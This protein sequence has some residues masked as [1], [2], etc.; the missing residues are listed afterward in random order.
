MT[1]KLS[2]TEIPKKLIYKV[3][4][5]DEN[6]T[7]NKIIIFQ[8]NK[9][10][11]FIFNDQQILE[12]KENNIEIIQSEQHIHNDDSIRLIK[13]KII[14]ELGMNNIAYE[15]LYLF[16]NS[17]K[18][19]NFQQAFK[20]ITNNNKILFTK[21]MLGQLLMNIKAPLELAEKLNTNNDFYTYQ[22][23]LTIL[24]DFK[25]EY[26]IST[27]LGHQFISS[28]N[29]LYSANPYH[30]LNKE[31]PLFQLNNQNAIMNFE[32]HI[33]LD[34]PNIINNTLYVCTAN[35]VL[36]YSIRNN[37]NQEYMIELYFP[38]LKSQ[39]IYNQ[40]LLNNNREQIIEKNKQKFDENINKIYQNIDLLHNMY[41]YNNEIPFIHKGIQNI[42]MIIH[43]DTE[44]LLPLELIF[45]H[46]HAN[47]NM[48]F[49]KYN[50]G[51][52]REHMYRL[53]STEL[54]KEG[55]KIPKL[56]RNQIVTLSK[57][58]GK[59]K[60]ISIL[61]NIENETNIKYFFID[62]E[63][64]GNIIVRIE[65]KDSINEVELNQLLIT[66]VNQVI[67]TINNIIEN[68][69]YKMKLFDSIDNQNNEIINLEYVWKISI[70]RVIKINDYVNIFKG[71][72]NIVDNKLIIFKRVS[73]Y[74]E[75]DEINTIIAQNYN[76]AND[77]SFIKN[78]LL[79]NFTISEDE[80][81][82]KIKQFLNDHT[83]IHGRYVNKS[84]AINVNPGIP[85]IIT[86]N[87]IVNEL[88]INAKEI[89]SINYIN[90]LDV[91]INNLL[92]ISQYPDKL[93]IPKTTLMKQ[94]KNVEKIDD[95][96]EIK[97]QLIPV[98][99][100]PFA[101]DKTS[102]KVDTPDEDDGFFFESDDESGDDSSEE[103][104]DD[105]LN[106]GG[107]TGFLQKMKELEPNLFLT[108][109]TGQ[110]D[111]YSRSCPA[112]ISRQPIILTQEE[113][114]NIDKEYPGSYKVALP[115]ST[116]ENKKYWYIC[117][118]YWCIKPGENRPLSEE[119]VKDGKCDGKIIPK[120][121]KKPP[122][123]H[124]IYEFNDDKEHKNKDGSYRD[125]YPGLLD[126]KSHPEHCVPC[127]FK[128]F[129]SDQQINRRKECAID[130]DNLSGNIKEIYELEQKDKKGVVKDVKSKIKTSQK[131]VLDFNKYP[132]ENNRWGFL[133]LS[134]EMLLQTKNH[135]YVTKNNQ[136]LI[137]KD[138]QPLLRYGIEHTPGR[139][140]FI[141]CIADLYKK[142]KDISIH[143]MRKIISKNLTIDKFAIAQNGSLITIFKNH[144][145]AIEKKDITKH[146][147]SILF[148]TLD[149]SNKDKLQYMYDVISSYNN[150][151][152][153]LN[154][155]DAFIDHTYL[156][157]IITSKDIGIFSN[158]INLIIL[159][160]I[161]NDST[162]NIQ[163]L[164]P[165]N[166]YQKSFYNQDLK[167][168][169]LVKQDDFFEPIY[170]YGNTPN[171]NVN[172][173]HNVIKFFN[174]SNMPTNLKPILNKIEN[175]VNKY[176]KPLS[177]RPNVYSFEEALPS[178]NIYDLLIL[179]N[180]H[181]V[182]QVLNYNGKNIGFLVSINKD[183]LISVYVPCY[184]SNII[185]NIEITYPDD[186]KW[187]NYQD[188]LSRLQNINSISNN[189]IKCKPI[190]KIIEDNLI[191]GVLT[192]TNQFI[193][194]DTYEQNTEQDNLLSIQ[195]SSYKHYYNIDK[196]FLLSNEIDTIRKNTVQKISLE[197]QLYLAFRSKIRMLLNEYYNV[198]IYN[199]LKEIVDNQQYLYKNKLGKMKVILKH[200]VRN[201]IS[202]VTIDDEILNKLNNMNTFFTHNDVHLFCLEKKN[203]LCLPD[204]NLINNIENEEFYFTK[205][206]DELIRYQRIQLFMFNSNEYM[207]ISNTDFHIHDNELFLLQSILF[208]D[209]FDKLQPQANNKYVKNID[210]DIAKP[211]N[212]SDAIVQSNNVQF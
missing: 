164:C 147:K 197:T 117:P 172:S 52:K 59:T 43:P 2:S 178:R 171:N 165:T 8:G 134:V 13:K 115:Y 11:Q 125:F 204:K 18:N 53:Y 152:A 85:C 156:W 160:I 93:P 23:L 211:A 91:Y 120:G 182:K 166:S 176:C 65:I 56:S 199:K 34:Y 47:E 45:K 22:E 105:D 202:F 137:Q 188:T 159:D 4:I 12:N 124:Y 127:C 185:K 35:S 187:T 148:N 110:Y 27:T 31:E 140:S 131:N 96:V 111:A 142:E 72:F 74:T 133:P 195:Y 19:I 37:L 183:D 39:E 163:I 135:L 88:T 130:D 90:V 25:N 177:S 44:L 6:G 155:D 57:M 80:A 16:V 186:I 122:P 102:D 32:N 33:L 136:H 81:Q 101:L 104:S 94:M 40:Q 49:I 210:Y 206:A 109:K 180:F 139:Q 50:P 118:R 9:D 141:G 97:P 82:N 151:K 24:K 51:P 203:M 15:E 161:N 87:A 29:L 108:K 157:D 119:E 14:N 70:K 138:K 89:N 198:E 106:G 181:I 196:S 123:G 184:P 46:L 42:N 30:I 36:N 1:S 190:I 7:T 67:A 66:H 26:D 95:V 21:N 209:Y 208:G 3:H 194:L 112:S 61:L 145:T 132:I 207:N 150:F 62:I 83:Y 143:E 189:H 192:Q 60:Q 168:V 158:G 64:N 114:D 100:K 179:H 201:H 84:V 86:E 75:L 129:Y 78:I 41:Y 167:T 79:T 48:V 173:I 54:S 191:I 154:D 98:E 149:L 71:I 126:A 128:K 58:S 69:G 162:N 63:S 55:K 153:F 20:T 76:N 175:N 121:V 38:L 5:L 103:E 28:L 73:N 193:Q 17:I 10:Y 113:K 92:T 116:K 99:L 107:Y 146:Q 77:I 144:S 68:L 205:M 200:L 212:V 174:Q 169:I 170:L